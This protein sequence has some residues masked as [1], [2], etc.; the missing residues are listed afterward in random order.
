MSF[1][2]ASFISGLAKP[3]N[4]WLNCLTE[5][6]YLYVSVDSDRSWS[7]LFELR[8]LESQINFTDVIHWF[9]ACSRHFYDKLLEE[10]SRASHCIQLP[11]SSTDFFLVG[12]IKRRAFVWIILDPA[13]FK[14]RLKNAAISRG[15]WSD[16][17]LE[18][19]LVALEVLKLVFVVDIVTMQ[20]KLAEPAG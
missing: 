6:N 19:D 3:N 14:H 4:F 8:V 5:Y 15:V 13:A 11:H 2:I 9:A 10:S 12:I 18:V 7:F 16:L 20:I 17:P 1:G